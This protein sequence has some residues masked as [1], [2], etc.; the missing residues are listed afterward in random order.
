MLCC[1]C[2]AYV[3]TSTM[4]LPRGRFTS[5]FPT[6]FVYEVL[7]SFVRASDRTHHYPRTAHRVVVLNSKSY[8]IYRQISPI[9]RTIEG[10][11]RTEYKLRIG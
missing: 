4:S 5:C 6:T 2:I 9:P 11:A 7:V 8:W 10:V 3:V 1:T